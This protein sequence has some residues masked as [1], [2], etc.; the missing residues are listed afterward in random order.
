M[1][2]C[3]ILQLDKEIV[4]FLVV[5]WTVITHNNLPKFRKTGKLRIIVGH[6]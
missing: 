4:E 2:S 6:K 3:S 1:A 5:G